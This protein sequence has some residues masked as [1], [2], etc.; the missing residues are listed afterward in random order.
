MDRKEWPHNAVIIYD[1]TARSAHSR[2][3]QSEGAI[4]LEE[5][6]GATRQRGQTIIFVS[7]HSRKLDPN[8]VRDITCILYKMPTY[9]HAIW[10]RDE[11]DDLT[12][13]ALE[14]FHSIK[15]EKA[16]KRANF[17]INFRDFSFLTFNNDLPRGWTEKLSC[18]F[19][20]LDLGNNKKKEEPAPTMAKVLRAR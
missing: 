11:L 18:L 12:W 13:K 10:E 20:D 1:E 8:I 3:T 9:A 5:I 2:R 16:R 15:G 17:V 14:F 4:D 19:K 6:M 7:H